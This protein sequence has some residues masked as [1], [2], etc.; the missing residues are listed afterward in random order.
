MSKRFKKAALQAA[1]FLSAGMIL[2]PLSACGHEEKPAESSDASSSVPSGMLPFQNI[3]SIR[4]TDTKEGR[5]QDPIDFFLTEKEIEK[6]YSIIENEYTLSMET[7][8][9]GTSSSGAISA[10][11]SS[12]GQPR[13]GDYYSLHLINSD[14]QEEAVWIVDLSRVVTDEEGNVLQTDP[15]IKQWLKDIES[16]H[17]L[18]YSS[19]LDRAPGPEYFYELQSADTAILEEMPD[20]DRTDLLQYSF[21]EEETTELIKKLDGMIA[22]G[23]AVDEIQS[24]PDVRWKLSLYDDGRLL[25][26]FERDSQEFVYVNGFKINNKEIETFYAELL[27]TYGTK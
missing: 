15:A 22:F 21:T 25:Y 3:S 24:R 19:V 2:L 5:Y 17:G 11:A 26:D 27:D 8:S 6:S 4:I 14:G 9:F 13:M 1:A 18:S 10:E 7:T 20:M 23:E 16:A 12:A